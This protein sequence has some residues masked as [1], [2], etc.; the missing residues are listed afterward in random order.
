MLD[1]PRVVLFAVP[2]PPPYSGPEVVA[3]LLLRTGLGPG[4]QIHHLKTN[5]AASNRD[6]GSLGFL[7]ISKFIILWLQLVFVMIRYRPVAACIY[8]SQNKIGFIRAAILAITAHIF[9][10]KILAQIHGANFRHFYDHLSRRFQWFI[11]KVFRR[12]S[13]VILLAERLRPQLAGIY[14]GG[15]VRVLYNPVDVAAFKSNEIHTARC[16]SA[17]SMLFIGHL[18]VAKGFYDLLRAASSVLDAIPG[19]SLTFAGEWLA[20]ERNI[21]FSEEGKALE[22]DMSAV[23]R[24]WDQLQERYG[25]RLRY[26][27]VM[28]RPEIF[29]VLES[30]HIFVLPSYSEGLSMAVLEAMAMGLP[31]VVTPVGALP[32]ILQDGVN[33]IL[34]ETGNIA[35]LSSAL[36]KLARDP[37]MRKRMGIANQELI[38]SQH[39]P[40]K[41]ARKLAAIIDECTMQDL[42]PTYE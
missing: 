26:L 23:R 25:D 11:R 21:I 20:E 13:R 18:S 2:T 29:R 5:A 1:R 8:L 30:A 24:L 36:I 35:A 6:K 12:F 33:G 28:A 40:K 34:V 17:C 14:E 27:G 9:G 41:I 32:E 39:T 31:L 38:K 15:N 16:D 22:G 42:D 37:A 3:E 4:F 10:A 19:S 7:K